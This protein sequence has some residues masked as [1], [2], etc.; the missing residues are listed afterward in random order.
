MTTS[1]SSSSP[2]MG[3]DFI[4]IHDL[5]PEARTLWVS[6]SIIDCL[7]YTPEEFVQFTTYDILH[8]DDYEIASV[9][10][11]ENVLNDMVAS[12]L[13]LRLRTKEGSYVATTSIF[14][15]CYDF[16][17]NCTTVIDPAGG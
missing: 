6:S 13:V 2:F 17:I 7:G 9:A 5:T 8:P 10:H 14:S 16:I 4:T 12:Q 3:K 1:G 11:R 15:L